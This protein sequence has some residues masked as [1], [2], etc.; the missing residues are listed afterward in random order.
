MLLG[1]YTLT[2]EIGR[3]GMG[4]VLKAKDTHRDRDVAIKFINNRDIRD[5]RARLGLIREASATASLNHS[6][7]VSIY[8]VNQYKGHLYIV[9]EYLSGAPLNRL[10]R[11]RW[12][13]SLQHRL[14]I[15]AEVCDALA[16]AHDQGVVHRDIKPANIFILRNGTAKVVDFGLAALAQ[17][18]TTRLQGWAGTIPYMSPEQINNSRVDARSDI[19]AAGI[20]LYE[21]LSGIVPFRGE[22][23]ASVF[24]RIL[25][26]PIPDLPASLPLSNELNRLLQFAL[27]KNKEQ[28]CPSASILAAN[29]RMLMPLAQSHRW[30]PIASEMSGTEPIDE[31]T[32]ANF[33]LA[34]VK[35]EVEKT[36]V[37]P[38]PHV[39]PD[40]EGLYR[41]PDLGFRRQARG[42]VAITSEE[43]P[44]T[45]LRQLIENNH[46]LFEGPFFVV[47]C[48]VGGCCA[49]AQVDLR[50]SGKMKMF[51]PLFLGIATVLWLSPHIVR[52]VSTTVTR[53]SSYPRC[54][55]CA[56]PMIQRS[57]WTRFVKSNAEVVLGYRDCAAALQTG[58]WEDA[59][60]L[61]TIH[62]HEHESAYVSRNIDT[63]LRYH[64]AF[65][66]CARCGQRVG[67]LTVSAT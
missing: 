57:R 10:I 18:N 25:S 66:E 49:A 41:P 2:G 56:G 29:L 9:M 7:I 26:D 39:S 5:E 21:L 35:A 55:I 19:W 50:M 30:A 52:V 24:Q 37:R 51:G 38:R 65:Y 8:D 60:K 17:I 11:S 48:L 43:F 6:N 32:L 34:P 20:T 12:P 15:I 54:S 53:I 22:T 3:G 1:P 14:Q 36:E 64:L 59:A 42:K 13:L 45:A 33:D 16:F 47:F 67:R 23:V 31:G 4:V 27:H 61:L 58:F 46:S 40:V 63:A 44:I 28:R 62:G